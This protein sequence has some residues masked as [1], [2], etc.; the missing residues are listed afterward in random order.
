MQ[1]QLPSWLHPSLR[2]EYGEY[3]RQRQYIYNAAQNPW[4]LGREYINEWDERLQGMLDQLR[5][6]SVHRQ[7]EAS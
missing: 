1:Q 2:A 5:E 7:T 4:S 3:L 6:L